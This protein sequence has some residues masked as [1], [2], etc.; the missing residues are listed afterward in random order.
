[1]LVALRASAQPPESPRPFDIVDNS[2]LVEEA[3]NQERGVFQNIFTATRSRDGRWDG[4]FTQEWPV[5]DERHQLS[6]TVPF[7]L[8]TGTHGVG[9]VLINYRFQALDEH[10]RMPAFSP[11]LSLVIPSGN[12]ERGLGSG[13]Y[14]W[15]LNLPFSKQFGDLY[16]HWNAGATFLPNAPTGIQA[17]GR[18]TASL[19]SPFVAASAIVRVRPMFNV[20]CEYV[21][22]S[23]EVVDAG[24]AVRTA[25]NTVSPGFRGGWNVGERQ[26]IVGA[27][28]PVTFQS[29]AATYGLLTYFS[30]ES[31]FRTIAKK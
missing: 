2:F 19:T 3:F 27:A 23:N 7:T 26:L 10:G 5:P 29:G 21:A 25:A 30:F 18:S 4:S 14:G 15:Q 12:Q 20:L 31:P 24:A 22:A 6:Y 1:M 16:V 28:V 8:M 13:A 17:L 11:R 9:D